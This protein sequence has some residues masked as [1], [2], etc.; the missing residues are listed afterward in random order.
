MALTFE[1]KLDP[2]SVLQLLQRGMG[3]YLSS[4]H[5][6]DDTC[7]LFGTVDPQAFNMRTV[8]SSSPVIEYV[9]RPHLQALC[10]ALRVSLQK[11]NRASGAAGDK[12][13]AY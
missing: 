12:R 2:H 6:L 7:G 1:E 5:D 3:Y 10:I 13:P 9:M 4:W 11:R 8:G